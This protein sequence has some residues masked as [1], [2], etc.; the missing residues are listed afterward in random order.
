MLFGWNRVGP[1]MHFFATCMV[2]LGT[3]ISTF[4]IL[5]SNS[6]MQTPQGFEIVNGQVVPVDWFAVIFNPS[7]PYRL[8][9]MTVAA[10]LSSALFVG[11]RRRGICCAAQHAGDS[12][13]VFNGAV[14][15]AYRCPHPGDDW[16]YARSEHPETSA[17]KIAAIEGHWENRPGNR[18][19]CCCSAG[20]IWRR[21]APATGLRSRH[22]AA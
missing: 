9:H 6:W 14:D 13:H 8:L 7:F 18:R 17:G 20:R 5:A 21:S 1:G 19:P 15:D 2:A 10:F 16:R 3:I 4:W 12:R 22:S 11:P